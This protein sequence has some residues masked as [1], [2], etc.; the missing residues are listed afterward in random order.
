[1]S[2]SNARG[3]M[4]AAVAALVLGGGLATGPA[5][6]AAPADTTHSV[7]AR[8]NTCWWGKVNSNTGHA[9]CGR[10]KTRVVVRCK[11]GVSGRGYTV[12]GPWKRAGRWSVASCGSP[13]R[14][15]VSSVTLRNHS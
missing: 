4:A 14:V 5:A 10:G 6:Q 12:Y 11:D 8:A 15:T 9:K 7:V 13:Q 1:M 2:I 3:L